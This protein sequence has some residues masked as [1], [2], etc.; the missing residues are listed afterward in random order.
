MQTS[1]HITST[2]LKHVISSSSTDMVGRNDAFQRLL[3]FLLKHFMHGPV[4]FSEILDIFN[5]DK[6]LTYKKISKMISLQLID[7]TDSD[8]T[9]PFEKM[10]DLYHLLSTQCK[11]DDFVLSDLDGFP[12]SFCGFNQQQATN[13][14]AVAC[15]Y[16]KASRRSRHKPESNLLETPL[17]IKTTWSDLEII[18]YQLHLDCFS[19]LLITKNTDFIEKVEFLN[20][21]SYLFNRYNYE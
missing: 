7:M 10:T 2:G 17:S 14:S 6:S 15:D 4:L 3:I 16:V 21:A 12:I 18:I 19:C 5:N 8:V 9:E 13:I 11:N 20:L 1:Y